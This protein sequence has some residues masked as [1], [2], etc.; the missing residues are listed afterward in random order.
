MATSCGSCME[1][2]SSYEARC[3]LAGPACR[4]PCQEGR[5]SADKIYTIVASRVGRLVTTTF[6]GHWGHVLGHVCTLRGCSDWLGE[7]WTKP[8][9]GIQKAFSLWG[10]QGLRSSSQRANVLRKLFCKPE[11]EVAGCVR[12]YFFYCFD[13]IP[14]PQ[15]SRNR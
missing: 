5:D 6:T 10:R 8:I 15:F 11:R 12:K 4:K 2:P 14:Q 7:N 1:P 3:N 9:C 13:R